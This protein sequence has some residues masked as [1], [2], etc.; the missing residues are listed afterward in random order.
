M[1]CVFRIP[2][3]LRLVSIDLYLMSKLCV[4]LHRL[5]MDTA[6]Q[7]FRPYMYDRA[8]GWSKF[9]M[10]AAMGPLWWVASVGHWLLW[11]FDLSKFRPQDHNKV[12]VAL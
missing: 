6:W 1:L 2:S 10:E 4:H 8:T 5:I 11:H 7:P 12:K 9:A 3:A